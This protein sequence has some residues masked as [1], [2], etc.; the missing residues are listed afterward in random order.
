MA[1][2][3]PVVVPIINKTPIIAAFVLLV[4]EELPLVVFIFSPF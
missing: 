4:P 1:A 2:A 3:T